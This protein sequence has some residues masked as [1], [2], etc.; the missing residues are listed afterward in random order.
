M[1]TTLQKEPLPTIL[2]K[3]VHWNKTF[4]DLTLPN[5]VRYQTVT[6]YVTWKLAIPEKRVSFNDNIR[7]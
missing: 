2:I 3:Y 5:C 6:W 1:E 7:A 4:R